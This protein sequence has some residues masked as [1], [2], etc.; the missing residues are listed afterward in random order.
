MLGLQIVGGCTIRYRMLSLADKFNTYPPAFIIHNESEGLF[1]LG[2]HIMFD[3]L[4]NAILK[5]ELRRLE[6]QLRGL[7]TKED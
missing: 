4:K 1:D 2:I 7:Q 3:A 5:E 6:A